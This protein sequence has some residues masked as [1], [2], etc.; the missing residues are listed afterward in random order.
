MQSCVR[1][2]RTQ[3]SNWRTKLPSVL[4]VTR[5]KLLGADL[6]HPTESPGN[7]SG[8]AGRELKILHQQMRKASKTSE[9]LAFAMNVTSR[10]FSS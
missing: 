3:N 7:T 4:G 1:G 6:R 10:V 5:V 2:A 8:W 9:I